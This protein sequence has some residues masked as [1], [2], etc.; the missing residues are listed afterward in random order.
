MK[1]IWN[2]IKVQ[3]DWIALCTFILNLTGLLQNIIKNI[4][5][6]WRQLWIILSKKIISI[7]EKIVLNCYLQILTQDQLISITNLQDFSNILEDSIKSAI[8][9]YN[10]IIIWDHYFYKPFR[11]CQIIL[12]RPIFN[13][14]QKSSHYSQMHHAKDK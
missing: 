1:V 3:F 4:P 9:L 2:M 7:S 10:L 5:I 14:P 8:S 6:V 11:I 13:P 12:K